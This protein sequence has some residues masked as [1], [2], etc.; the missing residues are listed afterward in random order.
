M[1][2]DPL[3]LK[4]ITGLQHIGIPVT[5]LSKS[6]A[7]YARLGFAKI[8]SAQVPQ[9][10]GEPIRVAIMKRGNVIVELYQLTGENLKELHSRRDGPIDH[11]AFDVKDVEK[12]FRELKKSRL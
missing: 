11:I 12:A 6:E 9:D 1:G 7:Y 3:L 8:M 4:N 2:N 10:G 5:D